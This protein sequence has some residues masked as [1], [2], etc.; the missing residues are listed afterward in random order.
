MPL[1]GHD[2]TPAWIP[3]R[4]LREY[5]LP[6]FAAAVK[7]GAKTVMVNSGEING[8]PVHVN[9]HMLT[10]ILKGELQFKGFI[11]S[12]WQDIE[13]LYM[14]H[15]VAKDNKEAVLMAIN[16]GIDMSMV[17]LDY[18]FCED[19]VALVKEGKVPMSRVD[20]AVQRILKVKYEVGLFESP[21]GNAADFTK[22]NGP[23]HN[24]LNYDIAAE[25]ITLL[26]NTNNI[27]PL[28]VGKKILVT[29]P[30]ANSMRVLNG[31]W[32][33]NWQGDNSDE[34]E[35]DKNTILEGITR[36]F[37]NANVDY[38]EGANFTEAVNIAE[39]VKK[40]ASADVI[41]VC[42]GE[43]SYTETPG[44]INDLNI[45]P[46]Q[47]ELVTAL[48]KT[49]KPIVMVLA[50]G[51]PRTLQ[52]IEPF[53]NAVV[54]TYL[55]GNEGGNVVADMLVGKINPSGRL[56][57]TYPRF[58]NS[59][60]NYYHKFTE[61]KEAQEVAGYDPQ[62]EFGFGLSYTTF[63]YDNLK[64][65]SSSLNASGSITVTVDVTNTGKIA[66]KESVLLFVSDLV[67]SITPEAKR[68]RAFDKVEL[69]PGQTKKVTFTLSKDNISFINIDLKR[70]VEPG[71]FKVSVGGLQASFNYL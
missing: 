68:L 23:A 54:H 19:L 69:Q 8:V 65:S 57:Y 1:S 49:G 22:F 58:A 56:P 13:Y 25:C 60:H 29:G 34:T 27:L 66:G 50:E 63:K 52:S 4:E 18:T 55:L 59:L 28:S 17:P 51:R 14:R 35:K 7:A 39:T 70:V 32:S 12:D 62:W 53:A 5:F 11:V 61:T 26:K 64:L 48:S 46:S 40:A 47:I 16:A 41:V 43:N 42:I 24:K 15:K 2:R 44:N 36:V 10:D 38:S 20:D 33:R 6:Q 67:A 3:E 31:G 45:S 71:E 30:A 37:G 9:K 21:T